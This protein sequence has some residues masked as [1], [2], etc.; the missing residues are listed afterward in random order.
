MVVQKRHEKV[1]QSHFVDA[2]SKEHSA[3]QDVVQI[4]IQIQIS[5]RMTT[6]IRSVSSDLIQYGT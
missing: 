6:Q 2:L 5:N 1:I 4:Q 3:K